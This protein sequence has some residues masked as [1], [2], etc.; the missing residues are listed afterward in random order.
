MKEF[1][2]IEQE[3]R[4]LKYENS[5]T[6]RI[7]GELFLIE[8]TSGSE[9]DIFRWNVDCWLEE[10]PRPYDLKTLARKIDA[11]FGIHHRRTFKEKKYSKKQRSTHLDIITNQK[12]TF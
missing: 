7:D 11:A 2:I 10:D 3:N 9:I 4:I 1:E 5:Y 8:V 12:N 6:V